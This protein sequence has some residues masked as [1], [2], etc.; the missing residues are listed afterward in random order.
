MAVHLDELERVGVPVLAPRFH[1]VEMGEQKQRPPRAGAAQPRHQVALAGTGDHP[2]VLRRNAA[3]A[4]PR[5]HRL[6]GARRVACQIGGVDLDQLTVDVEE[7]LL[8]GRA[9]LGRLRARDASASAPRTIAADICEWS[10]SHR[11]LVSPLVAIA[12]FGSLRRNAAIFASASS[13]ANSSADSCGLSRVA[14]TMQ[15]NPSGSP[16]V[17]RNW[18]QVIAGIGDEIA[19]LERPHLAADQAMAAPAQDQ[20]RVHVL[21]PL[22]RGEAARRHLEIAQLPVELRVGEQHLAGDRLEQARSSSL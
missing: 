15:R 16:L 3:V 20:H 14:L 4:K 9:R 19:G 18:C 5:R 12:A 10:I 22:Q 7:G 2:D 1:H 11:S 21:V 8:V 6:R 17:A 13:F